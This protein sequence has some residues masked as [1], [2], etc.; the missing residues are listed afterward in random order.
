MCLRFHKL[1]WIPDKVQTVDVI[2]V[3]LPVSVC[4]FDSWFTTF[5]Y[6]NFPTISLLIKFFAIKITKTS[7]T[8]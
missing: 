1:N 2:P 7:Q 3:E 6:F 8:L 4:M 5:S